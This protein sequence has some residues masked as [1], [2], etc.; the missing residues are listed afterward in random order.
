MIFGLIV[1]IVLGLVGGLTCLST[2]KWR[3]DWL[4]SC[5]LIWGI[6]GCILFGPILLGGIMFLIWWGNRYSPSTQP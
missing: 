3:T 6:I 2:D 4:D 1:W 5:S